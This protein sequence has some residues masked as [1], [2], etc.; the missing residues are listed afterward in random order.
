[1]FWVKTR[2]NQMVLMPA[3][4][5]LGLGFGFWKIW[6]PPTYGLKHAAACRT[7][8]FSWGPLVLGCHILASA[9]VVTHQGRNCPRPVLVATLGKYF[10]ASLG[11]REAE[12]V[13]GRS[14]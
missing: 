5:R 1:M 10:V 9:I 7:A 14:K 12:A 8:N 3:S 4:L 6:V 11:G 2:N 13:F